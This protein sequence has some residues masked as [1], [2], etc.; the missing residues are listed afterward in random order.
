MKKL[1]SVFILLSFFVGTSFALDYRDSN[2]K[3]GTLTHLNSDEK[4]FQTFAENFWHGGDRIYT[5]G[6]HEPPIFMFY[7]SLTEMMLA[8]ESGKVNE[9]S[10]PEAVADYIMHTTGKYAV[11]CIMRSAPIYISFGFR[12]NDETG[13]REKFNQEL[14]EMGADG[15]LL[16]LIA[17]YIDEAGIH[18]PEAVEFEKFDDSD[19]TIRVA[20]TG[21]LPPIDYI[22]ADGKP[23][24][25]N[26]AVIA[27]IAK[28]LKVNVELVNIEAG[29]RAA[30]LTSGRTD[31]V[32][33][34]MTYGG[35]A[36]QPDVPEK[37]ALSRPY[38]SWDEFL[39]IKK[40]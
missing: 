30:S 11:T 8:L 27:E 1:F 10:L 21:D 24:G 40:F 15:T 38:Y 4:I 31:V 16:T 19:T 36:K 7:N 39:H 26:T 37:V 14:Q 33:W 9:I 29:A 6:S 12:E 25:F 3:V 18:E 28:R 17:K 32:F 35:I 13:L 23:A 22:A 2:H 5:T 20:V 34:F